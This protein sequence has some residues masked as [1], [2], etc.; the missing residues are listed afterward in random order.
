MVLHVIECCIVYCWICPHHFIYCP[1]PSHSSFSTSC[2]KT[3]SW[4]ST[5]LIVACP[6]HFIPIHLITPISCVPGSFQSN[7]YHRRANH[8]S[9]PTRH[10]R[11]GTARRVLIRYHSRIPTHEITTPYAAAPTHHLPLSCP[12]LPRRYSILLV[13]LPIDLLLPLTL[14]IVHHHGLSR[15]VGDMRAAEVRF[16]TRVKI[17]T[18]VQNLDPGHFFDP[19]QIFDPGQNVP[20]VEKRYMISATNRWSICRFE[21]QRML[22]VPTGSY[23]GQKTRS[24][25]I[26]LAWMMRPLCSL[27]EFGGYLPSAS[28]TGLEL[29]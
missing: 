7:R 2:T 26:L 16:L 10:I 20:C 28:R 18:L 21:T 3:L 8:G 13:Y 22:R 27:K 15:Y 23:Q 29:Y 24:S 25:T 12:G 14:S 19:G 9:M 4:F 17:L 6:H 11:Y 5:W 1:V